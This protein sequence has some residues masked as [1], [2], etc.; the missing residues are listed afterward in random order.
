[1]KNDKFSDACLAGMVF[2]NIVTSV[3]GLLES[4]LLLYPDTFSSGSGHIIWMVVHLL[5]ELIWKQGDCFLFIIMIV[6]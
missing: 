3:D 4:V 2:L 1:M 6:R 5:H